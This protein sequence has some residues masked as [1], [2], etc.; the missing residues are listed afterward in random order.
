MCSVD[1]E[2]DAPGIALDMQVRREAQVDLSNALGRSGACDSKKGRDVT[3][4]IASEADLFRGR[5]R[6]R[7]S[8]AVAKSFAS[9]GDEVGDAGH[10]FRVM[11]VAAHPQ[12]P[13]T[14][15]LR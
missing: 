2:A 5:A 10:D 9:M 8:P 11:G 1:V 14:P 7:G 4:G 6:R 15:A 13:T 12:K 3:D